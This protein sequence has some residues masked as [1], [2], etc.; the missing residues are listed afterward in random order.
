MSIL[1]WPESLPKPE[2]QTY[3]FRTDDPRMKRAGEAG[4]PAYRRLVS[5]SAS[6]MSLS[7]TV[8]RSDRQ[9][10]W[11]FYTVDCADGT[12]TFNMLDPITD[13][14][15]L[16]G[17]DG[18]PLL[19]EDG[20]PILLSR[21]LLCKWGDEPPQETMSGVEFKIGFGVVIMP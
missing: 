1:S 21:V 16:L 18:T 11:D 8:D 19:L 17:G 14:W 12:K 7:I 10:F 4:P 5:S 6:R 13:G 3:G 15:A 20:T 9:V 2:R